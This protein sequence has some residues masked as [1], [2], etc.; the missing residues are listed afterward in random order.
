MPDELYVIE[1]L[2]K[3]QYFSEATICFIVG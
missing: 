1:T 3:Q 2:A